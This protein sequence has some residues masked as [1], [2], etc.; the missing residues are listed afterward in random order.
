MQTTNKELRIELDAAKRKISLQRDEIDELYDGLDDLEQYSRKN[1]LEIVGIP[2]S[3]REHE[4]AVLKI[5]N[6]LNVQVKPEDIDI[7]HR[8]K[9]KKSAQ[10]LYVSLVI[11]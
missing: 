9:R 10:L 3:I 11:K 6:A 4:G 1:S 7:C 2:E 5:A 8:V